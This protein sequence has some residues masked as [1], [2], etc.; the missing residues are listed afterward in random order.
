MLIF[1]CWA[2]FARS[3]NTMSFATYILL[4]NYFDNVLMSFVHYMTR[5]WDK[6]KSEAPAGIEPMTS[7]TPGGRSIHWATRTHGG[8]GHFNWV[9]IW[10][11]SCILPG[12]A[13]SKSSWVVI[14]WI[15]IVNFVLGNKCERSRSSVDRASA[16]CSGGH[17]YDSCRGLR[18]F[19]V[20]CSR[21][22]G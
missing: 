15:K 17:G 4:Q 6:E 21:H 1:I 10:Q 18:F 16:R 2:T 12:L 19:F 5:A 7:R 3:E 11:A 20:P 14:K 22:V 13:L 8:N 9:Y